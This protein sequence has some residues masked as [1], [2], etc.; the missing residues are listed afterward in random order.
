MGKRITF[1]EFVN[2]SRDKHGDK[3]NYDN[4]DYENQYKPV[5]IGCPIHGDF[6]QIPKSHMSG[7]D[8]RKCSQIKVAN[9][10]KG[11]KK[12]N[13]LDDEIIIDRLSKMYDYDYSKC[14]I[15]GTRNNAIISDILCPVHGFFTKR[16]N[17]H[18]R[19]KQGCNLCGKNNLNKDI[20]VERSN[21]IHQ[22][23]YDY[24]K[25]E[26][27]D[28][29]TP[30]VIICPKHGEFIQKAD[31]HLVGQGCPYCYRDIVSKGENFISNFLKS[32]DINFE[33]Q[34]IIPGSKL[35][36]DFF[37]PI[38]NI[39]IEYDGIQH[40]E[41][42]T[43]FGGIEEFNLQKD[44]DFR[45]SKYCEENHIKLY[46]ISYK[47]YNKLYNILDSILNENIKSFNEFKNY[48]K[49]F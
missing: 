45:K 34:K 32:R 12:L 5:I 24:S 20:F 40:F 46:R 42:R 22:N 41:P 44:R 15:T 6:E 14:K 18:M 16:L 1:D 33:T 48:I 49:Y 29:R 28:T 10:L 43:I 38:K 2:R 27:K 17:N 4:V 25:F 23:K 37:I 13:R 21:I 47:N 39:C 26:Y 19:Q 36:M 30:S 8:C 31:K 7:S 11:V 35:K 3:F 9:S